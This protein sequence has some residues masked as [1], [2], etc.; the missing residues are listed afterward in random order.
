M[1]RHFNRNIRQLPHTITPW[2]DSP[3]FLI[4]FYQED[5]SVHVLEADHSLIYP[6]ILS[7]IM[8]QQSRFTQRGYPVYRF[9]SL[10]RTQNTLCSTD[11]V[12]L[13][14]KQISARICTVFYWARWHKTAF[15]GGKKR[16]SYSGIFYRDLYWHSLMCKCL[17]R[18]Y[19]ESKWMFSN[20]THF[21]SPT[22]CAYEGTS[23]M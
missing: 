11:I 4:R 6:L 17:Y 3:V 2:S 9:Q 14:D 5:W 22:R 19:D 10:S 16:S 1:T 8:Q 21:I 15:L 23:Q 7:G 12:Q 18:L 20:K 13:S